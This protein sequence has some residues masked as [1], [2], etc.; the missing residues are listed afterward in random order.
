[1]IFHFISFFKNF[2]VNISLYKLKPRPIK[3]TG[4]DIQI[5]TFDCHIDSILISM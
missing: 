1:M 4:V 3:I 2:F 5:E